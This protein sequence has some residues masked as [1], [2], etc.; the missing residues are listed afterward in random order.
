MKAHPWFSQPPPW[1]VLATGGKHRH[2]TGCV[3]SDSRDAA[4][5][6]AAA[7]PSMWDALDS[8]AVMLGRGGMPPINESFVET[9]RGDG[10][11]DDGEAIDP[12]LNDELFGGF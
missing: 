2:A 7:G 12:Q 6:A 5:A 11:D 4:A 1:Y 8:T 9:W 3:G 10:D